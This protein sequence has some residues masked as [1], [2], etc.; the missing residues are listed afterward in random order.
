LRFWSRNA[1]YLSGFTVNVV[2][3]ITA[4]AAP[5]AVPQQAVRAL[6]SPSSWF[7]GPPLAVRG[8]GHCG[9][10]SRAHRPDG[11]AAPTDDPGRAALT[12]SSLPPLSS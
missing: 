8:R 7:D 9:S 5:L 6:P 2:T 11:T 12:P 4:I 10:I 3:D 1:S